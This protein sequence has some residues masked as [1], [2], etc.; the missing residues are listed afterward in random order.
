MKIQLREPDDQG[1]RSCDHSKN[2]PLYPTHPGMREQGS[3][4]GP[5][6]EEYDCQR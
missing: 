4:E 3:G 2:Q 6:H 5:A 1:Q